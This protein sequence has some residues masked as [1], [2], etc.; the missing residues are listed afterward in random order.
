MSNM[1]AG[2]RCA[3]RCISL[4]G[5][6]PFARSRGKTLR[7]IWRLRTWTGPAMERW[8]CLGDG[9]RGLCNPYAGDCDGEA[10]CRRRQSDYGGLSR[11]VTF[12]F[13]LAEPSGRSKGHR[14][15][16]RSGD[17]SNHSSFRSAT[18]NRS[19]EQRFCAGSRPVALRE[20]YPGITL[21]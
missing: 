6:R 17:C 7:C 16:N 15:N 19:F 5:F 4:K 10:A 18:Q 21:R 9:R 2:E 14:R 3:R 11:Y 8:R 13:C 1:K 20:S 12:R